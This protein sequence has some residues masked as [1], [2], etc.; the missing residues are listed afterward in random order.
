[1]KRRWTRCS[2][3]TLCS[4]HS[5]VT[6]SG[7]ELKNHGS[8][9]RGSRPK[10]L[11]CDHIVMPRM[12]NQLFSFSPGERKGDG[13]RGPQEGLGLDYIPGIVVDGMRRRKWVKNPWL[14]GTLSPLIEDELFPCG[15]GRGQLQWRKQPPLG[16]SSQDFLWGSRG[17]VDI[18]LFT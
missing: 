11:L 1:M 12:R 14:R 5:S 10:E 2:L 16:S 13:P 3:P 15:Q 7:S 17:C 8:L 18:L 9:L 6:L 4:G